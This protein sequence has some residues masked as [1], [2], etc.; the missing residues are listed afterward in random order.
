RLERDLDNIVLKA[1]S[2]EPARRYASVDHL[3]DDVR[4]HLAGHPVLARQD[5]LG[6]RAAKFVRRQRG[7]VIAAA[8]V[9]LSLIGGLVGIAWQARVARFEHARAEQRFDDVR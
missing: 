7:A 4:R 9:V 1:L 3:A 6:Y 8:A 5:T 2:K